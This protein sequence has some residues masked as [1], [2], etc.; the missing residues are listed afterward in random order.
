MHGGQNVEFLNVKTGGTYS[1]HCAVHIVS[2][3]ILISGQ[4]FPQAE[5]LNELQKRRMEITAP[6]SENKAIL[7]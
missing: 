5:L 7:R 4:G 1:D 3:K 2:F 6:Y